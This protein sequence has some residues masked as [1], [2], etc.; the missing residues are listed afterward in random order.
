MHRLPIPLLILY[1]LVSDIDPQIQEQAFCILRNLAEDEDGISLVY[2][3][4]GEDA[5]AGC[6]SAGLE[7]SSELV[8]REVT[9]FFPHFF[10]HISPAHF[11]SLPFL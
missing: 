8:T 10:A 9:A 11:L 7:S 2:N 3:S 4:M 5:V 1:R 6:I